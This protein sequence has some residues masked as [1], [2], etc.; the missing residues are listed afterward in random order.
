MSDAASII[1]KRA[2]LH[3]RRR[4][5]RHHQSRRKQ[6]GEPARGE[7]ENHALAAPDAAPDRRR[8]AA[9][10]TD[11]AEAPP[12]SWLAPPVRRRGSATPFTLGRS[13]GRYR[14]N[15]A[16]MRHGGSRARSQLDYVE[17]RLGCGAMDRSSYP[18][19]RP[20]VCLTRSHRPDFQTRGIGRHNAVLVV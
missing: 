17:V 6:L 11:Q 16:R 7:T 4:P 13:A 1:L 5:P 10:I 19:R 3:R 14:P 20:R 18:A 2:H 9:V 8:Q 12:S 15:L